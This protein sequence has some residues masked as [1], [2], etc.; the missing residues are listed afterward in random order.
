MEQHLKA[1]DLAK[2]YRILNIGATCLV[3]ASF[4]GK[5]NYL[6]A[7]WAG[8]CDFDKG[9]AIIDKSHFTRPLIE[10]S[11]R[12]VLCYPCVAIADQVM[13]LG[14][15]SQN[16]DPNKLEHSGVELINL[17]GFSMPVVKGC[18]AYLEYEVIKNEANEQNL[19][20]FVGRCVNVVADSRVYDNNHWKFDE[21]D[22]S[23]RTLHYV[24]GGHFYAIGKEVFLPAYGDE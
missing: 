23:L 1:Q 24:A 3:G 18:V 15:I 5:V 8:V 13:K 2:S 6:A 16:D 10:K 20:M 22:D 14:T 12:F 9:Y 7:A 11:G 19:D 17:D 4:E 21:A